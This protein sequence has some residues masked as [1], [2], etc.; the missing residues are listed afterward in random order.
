MLLILQIIAAAATILT[1]LYA[2]LRPN[3]ITG[4]TGIQPVGGRGVTEIRAIFGALLIALGI[5]PLVT[6]S[7]IAYAMLGVSYLAIGGVRLVSIFLDKSGVQS[8]WISLAVE[9]AFGVLLVL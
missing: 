4:F 6:G 9:I 7:P 1:G 2:L 5:Y 8:N 3:S